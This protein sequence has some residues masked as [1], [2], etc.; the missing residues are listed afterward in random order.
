[1]QEYKKILVPVD[2]SGLSKKALQKGL[3]LGKTFGS[4]VTIIHVEET[5]LSGVGMPGLEGANPSLEIA[6]E[7]TD[8]E[9]IE[10]IKISRDQAEKEGMKIGSVHLRGHPANEII[11]VSKDFDLI[12]MGT[13]GN[14]GLKH[15]LIGSVAEKVARHA[16]CPVLLIR[17]RYEGCHERPSS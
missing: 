3:S 5:V 12:V 14:G 16:C 1:M 10:I 15:L 8:K 9:D 2:G 7:L 17:E 11:N 4:E 13:H 6:Q